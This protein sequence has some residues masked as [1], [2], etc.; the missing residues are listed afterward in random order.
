MLKKDMNS[1]SKTC[2]I[3]SQAVVKLPNTE[4]HVRKFSELEDVSP[5]V[6][7]MMKIIVADDEQ[8]SRI[9]MPQYERMKR[10][11]TDKGL[12]K[13]VNGP[14]IIFLRKHWIYIPTNDGSTLFEGRLDKEGP[15]GR[16]LQHIGT[17]ATAFEAC[18]VK[19]VELDP[20]IRVGDSVGNKLRSFGCSSKEATACEEKGSQCADIHDCMAKNVLGYMTQL[21]NVLKK[22]RGDVIKA[23]ESKDVCR[24]LG[25]VPK[26]DM[27]D[28]DCTW[29]EEL[30][31]GKSGKS[32]NENQKYNGMKNSR[33][34]KAALQYYIESI[35]ENREECYNYKR[36]LMYS[37]AI[38]NGAK[39]R[40]LKSR[41]Q[42]VL[43]F[44]FTT[45]LNSDG[46][47]FRFFA[48]DVTRT[49][50][51]S[52]YY[53]RYVHMLE[54]P[55]TDGDDVQARK[56]AA[57]SC[58][59]MQHDLLSECI[60]DERY[61][62]GGKH[63]LCKPSNSIVKTLHYAYP[64]DRGL[65]VLS[66]Q[67]TASTIMTRVLAE[68]AAD[69][70]N[71]TSLHLSSNE[72]SIL[73][74]VNVKGGVGKTALC[75]RRR[76]GQSRATPVQKTFAIEKRYLNEPYM[77]M[78]KF[79]PLTLKELVEKMIR[80]ESSYPTEKLLVDLSAIDN[81]GDLIQDILLKHFSS[82]SLF[83][84]SESDLTMLVFMESNKQINGKR[85]EKIAGIIKSMW[86]FDITAI[87]GE[88]NLLA[89]GLKDSMDNSFSNSNTNVSNGTCAAYMNNSAN[90]NSNKRHKIRACIRL[91]TWKFVRTIMQ[92]LRNFI[93]STAA[94]NAAASIVLLKDAFSYLS[95][96]V[97]LAR[98]DSDPM[99]L[100][101]IPILEKL[102]S[103]RTQ[104]QV[105]KS[106]LYSRLRNFNNNT[107]GKSASNQPTININVAQKLA[108]RYVLGSVENTKLNNNAKVREKVLTKMM[109][110]GPENWKMVKLSLIDY[111]KNNN[112]EISAAAKSLVNKIDRASSNIFEKKLNTSKLRDF[113]NSNGNVP[114]LGDLMIMASYIILPADKNK[115]ERNSAPGFEN[116]NIG[117]PNTVTNR[118]GP[119]SSYSQ[120]LGGFN[121]VNSPNT[122]Q[123]GAISASPENQTKTPNSP[124]KAIGPL[125]DKIYNGAL[126]VN[127]IDRVINMYKKDP[128]KTLKAIQEAQKVHPEL[129]QH[130]KI[131]MQNKGDNGPADN[132]LNA[133]LMSNRNLSKKIK[134]M[135]SAA[136]KEIPVLHNNQVSSQ[137]IKVIQ[138]YQTDPLKTLKAI[139]EAQKVHPELLQHMKIMMQKKGAEGAAKNVLNAL[140]MS[141]SNLSK[142]IKTMES[143]IKAI[144]NYQTDP[145]TTLK[146]IQEAQKVHPDLL[147]DMKIMMQNK[148]ANGPAKNVLNALLM[149]NS[150]LS[151]KIK[152]M[153]SATGRKRTQH[154]VIGNLNP[155][156]ARKNVIGNLNPV[157]IENP[158][159]Y[160]DFLAPA[161]ISNEE[162]EDLITAFVF[163]TDTN[164]KNRINILSNIVK[165]DENSQKKDN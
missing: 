42:G 152:T 6:H 19:V 89:Q 118:S 25:G 155:F 117:I 127:Q 40:V 61:N 36:A 144:Q 109:G 41:L 140:L 66:R 147:E 157:A 57:R 20:R 4:T 100:S 46:L 50:G 106:S 10:Y 37:G 165:L 73:T 27:P 93:A 9:G 92:Q 102:M 123:F 16:R 62:P 17:L 146:A 114:T 111:T 54:I 8:Q 133:L 59:D 47:L 112:S 98:Q 65:Q 21:V 53:M 125:G 1:N 119:A 13:E 149:S 14:P 52:F 88:D 99:F 159:G 137:I 51:V 29:A 142:K 113:L 158:F 48:G 43:K 107:G 18:G 72:N 15:A 162:A 32:N 79:M 75:L 163:D 154:N 164:E 104:P 130:M 7:K 82:E 38:M 5:K 45:Y 129:L 160:S 70:K 60:P 105:K 3:P 78:L 68:F 135:E 122:K 145:L 110:L 44:I 74:S 49:V 11:Y 33:R 91:R 121:E 77:Q 132:I 34:N 153:E 24:A 156:E 139:Q 86:T 63:L 124:I 67:A 115:G 81:I 83:N 101:R 126:V 22:E 71:F 30:N 26:K 134:N 151:K 80:R 116:N 90:N 39:D 96:V 103:L 95:D 94:M 28:F 58:G 69:C 31:F 35:H 85:R 76:P 150:N 131:M 120:N 97:S 64:G 128:L 87:Q 56:R 161:E 148:G 55:Q 141:K 138:N 12:K 143:A 23:S 84:H 136:Q 108:Q 2:S